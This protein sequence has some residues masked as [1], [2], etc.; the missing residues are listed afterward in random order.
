MHWQFTSQQAIGF[1]G[2]VQ[3]ELN[4]SHPTNFARL[5]SDDRTQAPWEF[6]SVKPLPSH[7]TEAEEVYAREHDLIARFRQTPADAYAFQL[8]WQLL[9]VCSPFAGGVELWLSIQTDFLDV[10]PVLEIACRAP[11]PNRWVRHEHSALMSE[12]VAHR[13]Q[14]GRGPAAF[15]CKLKIGAGQYKTGATGLWLL[16]PSDQ[17]NVNV[18]S[19][20]NDPET[21]IQLFGHFM[22]KGVLRR[23]RMRF[24]FS[25]E[26]LSVPELSNA[27]REFASSPL[28]LTA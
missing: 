22:E 13:S 12:S 5:I 20:S 23:A 1:L 26:Q 16:E 21:R 3:L 17:G 11:H 9:P 15:E 24:L 25:P 28:P 18:V 14:A 19:S 2:P 10:Q 8:D 7:A 27:Y 6:F 4:P